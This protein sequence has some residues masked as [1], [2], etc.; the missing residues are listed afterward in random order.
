MKYIIYG[1]EYDRDEAIDA[2][3]DA[4][5][6]SIYQDMLDD[7]NG[8]FMG[9]MASD[10]LAS[11]DPVAYRIGFDEFKDS[12]RETIEEQLNAKEREIYDVEVEYEDDDV[13]DY[14]MCINCVHYTESQE[15]EYDITWH[16][17][18]VDEN[19]PCY[20]RGIEGGPAR[21]PGKC[22]HYERASDE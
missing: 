12:E 7:V 5:P 19:S 22:K 21:L 17:V 15:N 3:Q 2:L 14:D 8:E 1:N 11:T 10:I 4:I 20:E 13:P 6:E 18:S 16:E 9:Y